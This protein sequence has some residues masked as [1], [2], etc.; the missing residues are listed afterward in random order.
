MLYMD[1]PDTEFRYLVKHIAS[2]PPYENLTSSIHHPVLSELKARDALTCTRKF[3]EAFI[4]FDFD[5]FLINYAKC[6]TYMDSP[7][8]QLPVVI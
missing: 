1:F 6:V 5:S 2:Q 8:E 3:G 7:E 4:S